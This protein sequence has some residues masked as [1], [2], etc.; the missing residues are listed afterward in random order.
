MTDI[1]PVEVAHGI[2]WAQ[3][4]MAFMGLWLGLITAII[5]TV[6]TTVSVLTIRSNVTAIDNMEDQMEVYTIYINRLDA[7]LRAMGIEPPPLSE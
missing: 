4:H 1:S 2:R 6:A 7:Q 3:K 5:A